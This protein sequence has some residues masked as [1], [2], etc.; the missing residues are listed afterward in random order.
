MTLTTGLRLYQSIK[1]RIYSSY[2]VFALKL[3]LN[4]GGIGTFMRPRTKESD[5]RWNSGAQRRCSVP[6]L[7]AARRHGAQRREAASNRTK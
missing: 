5:K 3:E 7:D 1:N 2:K 4:T 6:R